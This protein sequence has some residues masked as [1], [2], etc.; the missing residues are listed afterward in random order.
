MNEGPHALPKPILYLPEY[1]SAHESFL[2]CVY[3]VGFDASPTFRIMCLPMFVSLAIPRIL[4]LWTSCDPKWP[5]KV[6]Q[7]CCIE[8][9]DRFDE[10]KG[11]TPV[12][13]HA[14]TLSK[15]DGRYPT[16]IRRPTEGWTGHMEVRANALRWAEDVVGKVCVD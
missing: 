10:P 15:M 9:D 3:E 6:M 5:E 1:K 8:G 11:A 7:Q 16:D 4:A 2:Y 12:G 14:T 13:W